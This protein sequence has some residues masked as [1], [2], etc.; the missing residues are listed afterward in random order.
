[1]TYIMKI[2]LYLIMSLWQVTLCVSQNK[3][4]KNVVHSIESTLEKELQHHYYV[5]ILDVDKS[6]NNP[7]ISEGKIKDPHKSLMG[8]YIFI[9]EALP[10]SNL[11]K[12]KG[13][14][15]VWKADSILWQSTPLTEELSTLGG[16]V[17][18]VDELNKDGKDEIVI[19]QNELPDAA[20]ANYLWIFTW[21]GNVGK[22]ITE[23]DEREESRLAFIGKY[24][25]VDLDGDSIYEIK[26]EWY[27][28]D[29]FDK[30]SPVIYSWNG[31]LYGK[32]GKTSK[33]LLKGIK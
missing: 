25:F 12:S 26:G 4:N 33:Y 13:F 8:C 23:L 15:G 27:I 24:K 20:T 31:S 16:Y 21:D 17:T 11:D 6:V 19:S 29:N 5:R 22:Q 9:A 14:I 1:M 3:I 32:W 7:S 18:A 2:T 28:D 10:D 30:T